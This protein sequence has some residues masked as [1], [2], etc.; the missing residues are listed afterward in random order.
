[1]T[2]ARAGTVIVL[3]GDTVRSPTATSPRIPIGP[4]PA[5]VAAVT[6][7]KSFVTIVA[8]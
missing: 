5:R 1:M 3:P 4:V 6:Q 2:V 7:V 8:P